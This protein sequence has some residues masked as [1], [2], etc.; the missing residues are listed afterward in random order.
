[1]TPREPDPHL[2]D[3]AEAV[4]F[5]HEAET[6]WPAADEHELRALEQVAAVAT[7]ALAEPA[8]AAPERLRA[9]LGAD[10]LRFCAERRPAPRPAPFP[11]PRAPRGP[12]AAAATFFS[13]LA[14]GALLWAGL[15]HLP[16]AAPVPPPPAAAR[17][18]LLADEPHAEVL[19]WRTGP[20]PRAGAVAGDVVW[21]GS[22]QR[23]FLR[24]RGLPPCDADH[25]FQLWIVDGTREG[26]PVDG[27]LFAIGDAAADT[28]V[29]V[30]PKLPIGRAAG[31]VVTLEG[32]NGAVVSRQEHVVAIAG[33]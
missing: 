2:E 7:L 19:P 27:G 6:T 32:A 1:M 20:S 24:F 29:P 13:G 3:L 25:R 17:A 11:P 4:A 30:A 31:F 5:A 23:G 16:T 21:S 8:P 9:R 22:R 12:V 26:A 15:G 28:V 18:T 14:A 10:G 33:L